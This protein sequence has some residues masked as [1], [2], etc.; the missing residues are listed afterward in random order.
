MSPDDT[1]DPGC[2]VVRDLL[3]LHFYDLVEESARRPLARHPNRR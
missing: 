1:P 2:E 3:P